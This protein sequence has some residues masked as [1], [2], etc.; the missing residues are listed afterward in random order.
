M[1]RGVKSGQKYP[2]KVRH[3]CLGLITYSPRAYEFIRRTFHNHLPALGTIK[4]WFANSDICGDPGIQEKCVERLQKIA[5][6][7]KEK[8]GCELECSLIF[9]EIH[10]RQQILFSYHNMDYVGYANYGQ[11]SNDDRKA[12][13]K[14]AIVFLLN[15][16]HVNF[17]YPVAY[18]FIH[19]LDM[20]KRKE[21]LSEII[22][23]VTR[24]GIKV[25]NITCD[26]HSANR[27][28]LTMLGASLK[29]DSIRPYIKNPINKAPIYVI[30]DPC[31]MEK[32]VRNRWATC[33][34]LSWLITKF[35]QI[36]TTFFKFIT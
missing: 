1:H 17:E 9:D 36:I 23:M 4:G 10:L 18:Y 29:I 15:G 33:K 30:F 2:E 13:A 12:I 20:H 26:G 8:N 7:F 22:A 35:L 5:M 32:L 24:C 28:A 27:P 31:H 14:Q 3:F 25:I 19:E 11:K 21:L 6:E 34:V 16:V